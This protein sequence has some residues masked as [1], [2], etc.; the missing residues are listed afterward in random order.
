MDVAYGFARMIW[1]QIISHCPVRRKDKTLAYDAPAFSEWRDKA[2]AGLRGHSLPPL[3]GWALWEIHRDRAAL[4]SKL[5]AEYRAAFEAA[6]KSDAK[7]PAET[8]PDGPCGINTQG[9]REKAGRV[10]K[11]RKKVQFDENRACVSIG[12]KRHDLTDA[13][14]NMI[15]VLWKAKGAWVPGKTVGARP[16]KLRKKMPPPVARI[17]ETDRAQGYRIRLDLLE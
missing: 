15:A 8:P 1:V 12:G 4:A 2:I 14:K 13:Q 17:I 9:E 16:D 6:M 5:S 10:A 3:P 11:S 7:A